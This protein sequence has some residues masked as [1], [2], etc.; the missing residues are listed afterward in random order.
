MLTKPR[1][2]APVKHIAYTLM[3][4]GMEVVLLLSQILQHIG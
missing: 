2:G 4:L 1:L 3:Q